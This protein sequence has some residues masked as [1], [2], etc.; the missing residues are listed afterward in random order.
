VLT[1]D[2]LKW[3]KTL[4]KWQQKLSYQILKEK[5]ISEKILDEIYILFKMEMK[6]ED[7]EMKADDIQFGAADV[8]KRPNVIWKGVKNLHGVNKLK[9]DTELSVSEGL[10]V[11]YGENGSGKSGYTRLLNNA[12]VS[13]G[14]QEILPNIF[15]DRVEDVSANFSFCVDGEFVEYRYPD[16]K[17][18][19][20]FKTIRNFDSKSASEDMNKE[21]K[22]DFAPS[23]LSFFDQ[24]LSGCLEIQKKL[25][26]ERECKKR[27]NPTLKFFPNEGKALNSMQLLSE[28]TIVEDIKKE[29]S[30][31][32]EEQDQYE[33]L[34][35]ERV[36]L[37]AL[38]VNRQFFVISKVLE[39]LEN[40]EKKYE[41]F[42]AA[43]S[44]M[45]ID[46]YNQQICS[47]KRNR[48]V[49]EKDGIAL[50]KN[51]D[52]EK[53]GTE[54]WK[55][56][57]SA[58]K[59]YYDEIN[60]HDRCPLCGHKIS[61]K[62]LIF[63]Y[64]KYLESDAENN[65]N[66]AKEAICT[67]KKE[68]GG[69]DLSFLVESSIQEQWLMEN[70]R[71]E[72]ESVSEIFEMADSVR[73]KVFDSLDNEK[74]I[75]E[76]V[77]IRNPDISGL[78]TKVKEK[79]SSLNQ[80][81]INE[82]IAEC[83]KKEHEYIDKTKVIDILSIIELY[84]KYLKWDALAEKCKIKTRNITNK[85]KE[86]FE[87]YVTDDYLRT[88]EE[89]CRKLNANFDI[90]IVSRGSSGRTLKKLQIKGKLPGKVLSEGEQRA[91]SIANFLTEVK[92][93]ERNIGIVFDDPVCSL[94]H[95]RRSKIANRL[96]EEAKTRQVIIFTHEITFFMEL[97]TEAERSGITFRQETIRKVC[98]EPGD[99]SPVISWQGMNVKERTGKLK[100]DLQEIVAVFN[101]GNMDVYYYRAKE[102]CELLRESWERAVE[103]ILFND[104]IQRY[105]PCVQTQRLKKAPFTREL[106][107]ELE[108]GMSECSAWCHD[109]ARAIN[110]D[111]PSVD[112][113]KLYIECFEKYCKTYKAR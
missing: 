40:A 63:K 85:Q 7:G 47:L 35:K 20:P 14:D 25:D 110:V 83:T 82:R 24:M 1:D 41:L 61:E 94:D 76:K 68:L 103:E 6:L 4:P 104:A 29:F 67:S 30:V 102:W 107:I 15:A 9:S 81:S 98:D 100:N 16:N 91:I 112:D 106:Y 74:E 72:T 111:V 5:S 44:D 3:V 39:F 93:D 99:I 66:V 53:L 84:V 97:K 8:D 87:K 65:Y 48:I 37:E 60:K 86:L 62:D 28:K 78:I 101:S 89:E 23:E 73:K 108:R 34:K 27:D 42:K 46:A 56:F 105:N 21:S 22:I 26:A 43:I 70:F 18:E 32:K 58:A 57:I 45:K 75:R 52:I 51:D 17:E 33:Q 90:N 13:R 96:V 31:T 71:A 109:Q 77:V 2:I 50:F 95:K 59:K 36:S 64:W 10:T 11:I 12:F 38:N 80:A 69:L 54:E 88:F 113:L 55:N 79:Q 49:H 92:M 19:Y